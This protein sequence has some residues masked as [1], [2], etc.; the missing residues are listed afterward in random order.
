MNC[1]LSDA[2]LTESN[3]SSE[4]I[5]PAALG[6]NMVSNNLLCREC[7][8]GLAS[9]IDAGLINFY[10]Y[11]YG[12]VLQARPNTRTSASLIGKTESGEEI[13]FTG[14]MRA[15]DHMTIKL[16]DGK[17][18]VITGTE[19]EL[20]KKALKILR[21]FKGKHPEINPEEWLAR[22]TWQEKKIEELVYFSNHDTKHSIAGGPEFFRDIKKIAINFYLSFGFDRK[23][24]N[25]VINQVKEGI[26][27]PQVISKFYYPSIRPTHK[28]GDSEVSHVIKLVG[29][30][31]MGVLYCY[32]EL[33]NLNHSIILLN[34]HY[35]GPALDKQ[36]CY[37]VLTSTYLQ[38]EISLPFK[39]REHVTD[40]F[41][42]T[43][44]TNPQ[45]EAAYRRTRKILEASIRQKGHIS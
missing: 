34:N 7:N 26:P 40:H 41:K 11:L 30:P 28:L 22:A 29:D 42:L 31:Q 33:F 35:D 23:Y 37:D 5:I 16:P 9:Q 38:K 17:E 24:I 3:R 6:N 14:Q 32:V 4:H 13:R 27:A 39:N 15:D 10:S 19:D 25:G 8:N 43:I 21:Q 1:Y 45:G 36:Y 44:D 20:R 2:E 12:L 18:I